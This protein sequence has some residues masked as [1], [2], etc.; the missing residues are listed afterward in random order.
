MKMN[1]S[2]IQHH[3]YSLTELE[4]MIP[5]EREVYLQLLMKHLEEEAERMKAQ[6]QKM[7]QRK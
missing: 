5:W 2:M 4:H 6:R 1:F 3:K 7:K